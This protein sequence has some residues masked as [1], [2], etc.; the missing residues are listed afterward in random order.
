MRSPAVSLALGTAWVT[1]AVRILGPAMS[2]SIGERPV[3]RH[4]GLADMIRPWRA[5]PQRSSCA[6]L[7]RATSMPAAGEAVD[8]F[9]RVRRPRTAG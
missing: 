5:R 9:R 1:A 2:I 7:I 6:Q 3:E 8:E 4:A